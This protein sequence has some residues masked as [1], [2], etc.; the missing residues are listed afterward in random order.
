MTIA[1][2]NYGYGDRRRSRDMTT[3]VGH[4]QTQPIILKECKACLT[5]VDRETLYMDRCM[6]CGPPKIEHAK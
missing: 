1:G 2:I 3:T 6:E 4:G 5:L